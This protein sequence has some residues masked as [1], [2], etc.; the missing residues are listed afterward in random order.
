MQG[1]VE[2]SDAVMLISNKE[3]HLDVTNPEELRITLNSHT[4][5]VN[6]DTKKTVFTFVSLGRLQNIGQ[7][8]EEKVRI[9]QFLVS[10]IKPGEVRCFV[11]GEILVKD[12]SPILYATRIIIP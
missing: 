4:C 5:P 6:L 8:K 12:N 2:M 11:D 3:G 7:G 9:R 10:Q 1:G